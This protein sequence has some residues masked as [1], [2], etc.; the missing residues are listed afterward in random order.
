ME[1]EKV[2]IIMGA[3]NCSDTLHEAI[4]S[5]IKQTYKNWEFI[6]CDDAST[7]GTHG[8]LL[9]YQNLY[10][11]KF[12]ILQNERNSKLS[13]SLNRC[14]EYATGQYIARMDGDDLS[15]P[16]RIEKQVKFLKKHPEIDL[17]GSSMQRFNEKGFIDVI[18]CD[19]RPDKFTLKSKNPFN[20]ATILTYKRVYDRLG[21][22]TVSE[23]TTRAQDADLWFRFFKEG[24]KGRNISEPLYLVREDRAAIR[25]RTFKVRYN[26][27]KTTIIG[28]KMLDYPLSWYV[29]ATL[30][31]ITKSVTPYFLIDLYRKYQGMRFKSN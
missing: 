24:F 14:L 30:K 22:Y 29:P 1:Q 9:S 26:L 19:E 11:D 20:H 31:F 5:I 6:I 15:D 7:D 25:R 23:R 17:V 16:K 10:P 21:G 13:Y 2:S 4:D 28:Y 3:Y 12:I 18:S 8:I 27:F